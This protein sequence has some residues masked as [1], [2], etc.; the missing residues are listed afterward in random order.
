MMSLKD[1]NREHLETEFAPILTVTAVPQVKRPA[2]EYFLGLTGSDDGKLFIGGSDKFIKGILELTDDSDDVIVEAS[3]KTLVNLATQDS[4]CSRILNSEN[5]SEIVVK[6]FEKILDPKYRHADLVCKFLSNLTRP[7][8]C[9]RSVA[10][11]VKENRDKLKIIKFV[12]VL[13]TKDYNAK[14][15][16]HYLAPVLANL[17]QIRH[18]RDEIL[19]RDQWVIQRLLPF[20]NYM[21]SDIRRL[22]VVSCIKNCCFDDGKYIYDRPQCTLTYKYSYILKEYTMIVYHLLK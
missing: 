21:Q 14:A 11:I 8:E 4:T 9:A 2:V 12:T 10:D 13:C 17:S 18:I 22:G 19:T 15:D 6:N 3:Y 5:C 1:L 7:E 16:L 20:V